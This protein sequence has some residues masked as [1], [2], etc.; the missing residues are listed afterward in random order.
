M[1]WLHESSPPGTSW[2]LQARHTF[3]EP[4]DRGLGAA[5]AVRDIE[6]IE[7]DFDDAER[8]QDHR[9]VDVAHMGDPERLAGEFADPDAEHHAAF[10]LAVAL[11]RSRI[12]AVHHHRRDRVGALAGLGDVEAEHLALGPD[13]DRA[14]HRFAEQA[15]AQEHVFEPLL[16]QHVDRLAQREQQ[17]HRRGAGIFAVVLAAFA[18]GPVPIGRAQAGLLVHLAGAVVG[19]DEA[20]ARRRHQALLRAGHRDV[21]APGVHLERHAAERGHR[22]DHEQRRMAGGLDRLADRFDVVVGARGGVDLHREDRLD[23]V[24]LVL[25][26]PR[27]DLGRPD[28]AA[29]VA[30]QHLDLDAHRGRGVAPADREAAAF[31]HQDLVAARQH[32]GERA[33]QAPWPLAM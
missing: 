30:L 13:R 5:L 7:A 3:A 12:V 14:A 4:L 8:A 33:S 18:L 16:E 2:R 6:R 29:P 25:P 27:L 15:M 11:Q 24:V 10:L 9:R 20:E 23:R 32:V 1:E 19:G 28:R 21:D 22:I 31:Q 26:Q 17:M